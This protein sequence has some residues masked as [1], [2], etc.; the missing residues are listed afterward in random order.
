MSSFEIVTI[1]E[2]AKKIERKE[3][4]NAEKEYPFLGISLEGRGAFIRETKSGYDLSYEKVRKV[5]AGDFIYSRLFAWK[6]AFD[7]VSEEL[8]GCY[9]SG[10]FP[11][12]SL[13]ESK[14]IPEY[15]LYYFRQPSVWVVVESFC[16][17]T[18]KASRNR[19]KAKD[20]LGLEVPLPCLS[21]QL[22]VVSFL[23]N[24]YEL[25]RLQ[26]ETQTELE[27]LVPAILDKAFKGE[28]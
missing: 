17:S 18:T 10:E 23:K 26:A 6:G 1:C 28:L 5:L 4:V 14:V 7:I 22:R 12:F 27:A 13:D 21:E 20:F 2:I 11:F 3:V 15:L 9:V 19:F 8:D 16:H 24:V 25:K